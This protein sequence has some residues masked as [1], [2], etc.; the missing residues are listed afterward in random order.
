MLQMRALLRTRYEL[1]GLLVAAVADE[2]NA[3]RVLQAQPPDLVVIDSPEGG[4]GDSLELQ[5]VMRAAPQPSVCGD[6]A[7]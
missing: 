4:P 6:D 1:N 7:H 5:E 3:T 2:M